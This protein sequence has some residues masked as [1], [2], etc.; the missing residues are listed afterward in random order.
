MNKKIIFLIVIVVVFLVIAYNFFLKEEKPAFSLVEVSQGNVVQVISETGQVR[1]GEEVNLAFKTSGKIEKIYV[2]VGQKV[3]EGEILAEL[4][5]DQLLLQLQE[6]RAYLEAQK[7]RL[8]ELEKGPR[9]EEIQILQT[10]HEKAKIDLENL[11]QDIPTLLNQTYN[12]AEGAIRQQIAGFFLY[13]TEERPSYY[14]L[15][16]RSCNDQAVNDS[17]FQRKICD[18]KLSVWRTEI[19]NLKDDWKTLE[20]ALEKAKNYLLFFQDFL[21]RLNETLII[22]QDCKLFPA[23]IEKITINKSSLNL[24][25]TNVNNALTSIYNQKKAIQSQ[26]LIVQNYDEQINLKLAGA[27]PEQIDYQE[28]LVKQAQAKVALLESQI[29]E[30]VLPAPVNG[31]VIRIKK[32]VGEIVQPMLQDV[33]ISLLPADQFQIKADI[34]EGEILKVEVGNPVNI[35]LVSFSDQIFKGKIVSIEPAEKIKEGVVYYEVIVDFENAPAGL[36]SGMSADLEIQTAFKENV[37]VIPEKVIIKKD[38]KSFVE[39]LKDGQIEEREIEIGLRGRDGMVEVI[40]G[41]QLGEKIIIR[42]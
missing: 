5:K 37:L 4:E 14:E 40:S 7:T 10:Q 24:A 41:L 1:R 38:K 26:K 33:V 30:T 21:N 19:K 15:T 34:Y 23:E 36:K 9:I 39:I 17:T 8:I 42:R 16:Y 22:T 29:E 32:R 2:I 13:K 11:Y 12:L 18:E 25:L 31:E 6:V 20:S 27:T 35:S 28:A 3:K